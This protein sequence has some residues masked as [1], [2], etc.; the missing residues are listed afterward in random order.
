[1]LREI[2]GS[3]RHAQQTALRRRILL[4][5]AF[6]IALNVA[7]WGLAL[8][9]FWSYPTALSLCFLAYGLGLRHAVDADH[10][11]A[12]DNVTRKLMQQGQRPAAVGLFF[13][14]GHSTVVVLMSLLVAGGTGYIKEQFPRFQEI[15]GIIGTSVSAVFLL[16]I[17]GMNFFI[18]LDVLRRF[19]AARLK[20]GTGSEPATGAAEADSPIFAETKIGTVP[21]HEEDPLQD[22]LLA[23]GLL[24]RIL[25]PVFRLVGRSWHMYPVGF[26]FGLGFDTATEVALLGIAATQ[27]AEQTPI[28][29]IMVFPLLFT[30]GMCLLDTTDGIVMLGAYGWAFVR[31]IRKL[32]YNMTI[33]L[34][35]FLIALLIGS[36]EALSVIAAKFHLESGFFAV[37]RA[38]GDHSAAV[39]YAIIGLMIASWL[40]SI[41][42]YRM[43]GF[44]RLD[45]QAE[46]AETA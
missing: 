38:L 41:V 16:L 32:F 36:L 35:S 2:A 45:S 27:A 17:A 6:L 44:D 18:F 40:A 34:V 39:G 22:V 4:I 24:G 19:R 28:W 42:V 1:M 7:A 5:Y 25:R 26:L 31:P 12:I 23:P 30:S 46:V 29:S 10:I 33:T 21:R 8:A 11:A 37:V 43:A 13:S 9:L 3:F 15:G 20:K 14:F